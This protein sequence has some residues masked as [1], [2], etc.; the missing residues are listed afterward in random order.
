MRSKVTVP[1]VFPLLL[2]STFLAVS[3]TALLVPTQAQAPTP[4]PT[5]DFMVTGPVGPWA[6]DRT[7]NVVLMGPGPSTALDDTL[8]RGVFHYWVDYWNRAGEPRNVNVYVDE[9]NDTRWTLHEIELGFRSRKEQY[10][11]RTE[12]NKRRVP[13]FSYDQ[14]IVNGQRVFFVGGGGYVW[15]SN[16]NRVVTIS[17]GGPVE[18]A[19]GTFRQVGLPHV[20][21]DTYLALLPSDLPEITFDAAHEQQFIRDGFDRDFERGTSALAH[22]QEHGTKP[23]ED[24]YADVYGTIR[25][26]LNRKSR[27]FGGPTAREWDKDL[28]RRARS[29]QEAERYLTFAFLKAEYDELKAWWEQ[30]RSDPVDLSRGEGDFDRDGLIGAR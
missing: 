29:T 9:V 22:W 21:L 16:P 28:N 8:G 5:P 14:R 12:D 25:A 3:L 26:L 18:S 2:V 15:T 24:E 4:R 13:P 7:E 23:G 19:D 11:S 20:F 10:E 27:Y 17:G 30:H 1:V 6:P